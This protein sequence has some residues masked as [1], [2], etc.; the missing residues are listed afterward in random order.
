MPLLVLAALLL[1]L[2]AQGIKICV[3]TMVQHYVEDDYRGRVFSLY[4]TMFNLTLVGAAVLT[5]W[6]FP[7][8]D[9]HPRAVV[10]IGGLSG[11]R[12]PI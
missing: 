6:P 10:V 1:G 9:T 3:D 2:A 11:Y 7:R 12:R 5:P 8:T 4:D